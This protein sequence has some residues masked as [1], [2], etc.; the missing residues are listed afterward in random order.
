MGWNAGMESA[1]VKIIWVEQF[2]VE[3]P[4]GGEAWVEQ[5]VEKA[6][7]SIPGWLLQRLWR[8]VHEDAADIH[9]RAVFRVI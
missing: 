1:W 6:E 3:K 7:C 9:Q 5:P 8:G 4:G 2:E